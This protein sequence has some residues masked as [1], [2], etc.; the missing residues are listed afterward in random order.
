MGGVMAV[1]VSLYVFMIWDSLSVVRGWP[2]SSVIRSV[3]PGWFAMEM[4]FPCLHAKTGFAVRKV[5]E[6][7]S[8]FH[9]QSCGY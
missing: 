9:V 8:I 1:S 7:M 5:N 2:A 4:G 6:G 3:L